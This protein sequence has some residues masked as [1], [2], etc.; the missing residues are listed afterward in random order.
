M[1]G[2]TGIAN[3]LAS[4][5]IGV[6]LA[7]IGLVFIALGMTFL[8]VI[9]ILLAIPVMGLSLYFLNPKVQVETAAEE[10]KEVEPALCAWPRRLQEID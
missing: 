2:L 7:V 4:M 8:P 9:G 10:A 5:V 3:R 6:A 1:N